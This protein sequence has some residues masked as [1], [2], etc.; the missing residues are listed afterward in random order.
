MSAKS[1]APIKYFFMVGAQAVYYRGEDQRKR[2]LNLLLELNTPHIT[3][4]ALENL[5]T[6]IIKRVSA[7]TE[8]APT[9]VKDILL[10]SIAHLASCTSEQFHD[11]KQSNN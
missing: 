5:N 6:Q 9:D 8:V 2:S 4:S 1:K 10:L 11:V 7:E 3:Q